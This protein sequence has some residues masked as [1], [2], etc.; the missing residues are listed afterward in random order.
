MRRARRIRR[1]RRALRASI[2]SS[3]QGIWF[4]DRRS[5]CRPACSRQSP[6]SANSRWPPRVVIL[7]RSKERSDAAQTLGSMPLPQPKDA[8]TQNKSA[9]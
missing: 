1:I 6:T 4:F 2:S 9:L 3:A 5:R 7:G 8:T